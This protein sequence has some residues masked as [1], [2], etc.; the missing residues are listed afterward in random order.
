VAVGGDAEVTLHDRAELRLE[1]DDAHYLVVEEE[2]G[3]EGPRLLRGLV[4]RHDDV[5]DLIEDG[6]VEP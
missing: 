3:D 6:P 2:V 1:V 5:E 4:F